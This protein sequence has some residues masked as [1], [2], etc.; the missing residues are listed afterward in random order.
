[1]KICVDTVVLID[2]LKDEFHKAVNYDNV[3]ALYEIALKYC[4]D[5][6]GPLDDRWLKKS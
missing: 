2:V 3:G 4:L 1:V 5:Y 6:Q